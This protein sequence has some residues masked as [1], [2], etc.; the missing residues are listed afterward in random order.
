MKSICAV[1]IF[2]FVSFSLHAQKWNVETPPGTQKKVPITTD[3]GTWMNLDVSP[4]GKTIAFDLLGDIYSMPITGGKATLLAGG[5][6]WEIQPR[7][8]PD[9][10]Q[11]SYTSDKDG[12]DN[13][14]IMNSDGSDKHAVTKES[15]RLLNNASWTPDGQF[16]VARKHF[17]GT[18]SLGAGEMWLYHKTGGEGIQLTKRKN[19][20][21]DAGEPIV[22]PDGKYIYW[23]EDVTPG[24]DFQYNKDPYKGIYAIQRLNRQTGAIENVTGGP[25]GACRPQISSDG[26]LM[27]FVKRVRLKSVLYIH[28]L[29]TGEE[30]PI[31]DDLSHD[32]QET[33]AIFGVYP[34]FAWLPNNNNIIIYAKGKIWNIDVNTLNAAQIPF[35]VTSQQTIT[36]ALHYQQKVYQE[37]FPVKMIR[38]L[39]TSPDGKYVAFNAAGYIYVKSL[40]D[41]IPFRVTYTND[42]EYDPSFSPDGKSLVYIDWSD[43]M[44]ASVNKIEL[45]TCQVTKLTTEKGFYYTPK[46]N[47]KG[48][49]VV[50]RKGEGNEVSGYAFGKDP[51]IYIVSAN[52]GKPKMIIN[53]GIYPQFSTDDS[54]LYYQSSEGDKKAF[55]M[56]DTTGANQQTLYTSKYTTQF[57]PSPDGKWMAFTELFNCYITPMVYTGS[58]QDLSAT[59][60]AIPLSKLTRD[61][62]TY[63]HW[64]KDSQKL[65]WTLGPKYF[66]RDIRNAFPFAEGGTDKTPPIDTAGIDIGLNIK[67]DVPDGKIALKNVRIIT[68]RGDEVIENG[69]ILVN[70]NK[71]TTIGK[72]ADVLIPDDAKI[73][74]LSGKTIMPGIVDVHA[75]L[76]ASP[77]GISP[78][79]DWNYYA[80]LAY[81]VT[82]AHDPSS[83]TEMV[84]SQAEMLKAGNMVGPRVYSTGT[85][86]YG[87]D[88]D[89]K[90]VINS[91][92]DARS[93]LR[94]LKA[95][96]AFSVKSY[97]QPRRE[98]RQQIIEAARELQMEV[99]PEGGSTFFTNM[100]MI[101]DGHTGIEHNIPVWPVY[102]DV[103][104][105][106]NASKTGYTPTLIVSYGTQFGE[107]FW[108][109]RTEVWKNERLLTYTPQSI[110]DAR[111][112]RRTTS[113]YGDYGHIEVSKYVKQ[114]ADG[115][116]KV[117]LGSH[118]QIQGIGAHWELWML[119]QGGMSP[120]QAL[121]CATMNGAAY[122]GMDKEIGSLE[123]GKL[124]DLVVL[125]DN[126]LDNIRNSDK[127]K[128]VMVNGRLFDASSMNEI[129]N[130]EKVRQPFWWQQNRGQISSQPLGNTETYLFTAQDG[131]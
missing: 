72:A 9:G 108:Y 11:I 110:I 129:G 48:D 33:W 130:R 27:A 13:I 86:L 49:K 70:G 92:D 68:M 44:K 20:Q 85:I 55:K 36:D 38:Q 32:Q 118:G 41:G 54:R 73:Y 106:W 30:W 4:D 46:F 61:A 90:A 26:K 101:L 81:G 39:T 103:K 65:M 109:D 122:L 126:P 17:T 15:F 105:L 19:D 112:R 7:F 59:N 42:F 25:G 6:A 83:N 84:F 102:K 127:I 50:F 51:G 76:H 8:S 91:I 69:T 80:N 12:G 67:T 131:D 18:R 100:N 96:G 97:N 34:N 22:S 37:T 95:V 53:N 52:G 23:S 82:T 43:E 45:Q 21:E 123:L 2:L 64:S 104:S 78:Q 57:N 98:Q 87:A 117:N 29:S 115:G 35:E 62:G 40:P 56:M 63:L 60:K 10:K 79:Q 111:S 16:F 93:N 116:T 88:G 94:R 128:Y 58:P 3:E 107:N 77:D 89:F 47:N 5:K 74:D 31:Y 24:P 125:D 1:L 124:A 114:I 66:T 28:N 120:M 113:E 71:I 99:V 14:W 75:H 119:V 121:R